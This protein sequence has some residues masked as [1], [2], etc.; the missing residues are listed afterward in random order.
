MNAPQDECDVREALARWPARCD[1]L[2]QFLGG[3]VA[4]VGVIIQVIGLALGLFGDDAIRAISLVDMGFWVAGVGGAGIAYGFQVD[5]GGSVR[6]PGGPLQYDPPA[7]RW[8]ALL[9]AI[10]PIPLWGVLSLPLGLLL[11]GTLAISGSVYLVCLVWQR[12]STPTE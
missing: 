12:S 11:C 5:A 9:W 1:W 3:V 10:V 7:R 8:P 6:Y 4:A 2:V